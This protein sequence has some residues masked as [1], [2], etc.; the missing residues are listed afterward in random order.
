DIIPLCTYFLYCYIHHPD[1][2][3]FPTRRSSDLAHEIDARDC[4][5]HERAARRARA[6][7]LTH[8]SNM[9]KLMTFPLPP[10]RASTFAHLRGRAN[11]TLV[12]PG[13]FCGAANRL[14]DRLGLERFDQMGGGRGLLDS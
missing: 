6:R 5:A 8:P 9:T 1:L 7:H 4:H 10:I 14:E 11:W 3:S 12:H 13:S 2:H